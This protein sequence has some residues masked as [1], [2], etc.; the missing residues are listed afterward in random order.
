M[1]CFLLASGLL[2]IRAYWKR[3]L[4]LTTDAIQVEFLFGLRTLRFD[5]ILGR[6]SKATRYG[7]CTVLV[8]KEKYQPKLIVKEGYVVDDSYR[9][10]LASIPDLDIADKEKR[11][12]AGKLHFWES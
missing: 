6:R 5:D 7:S 4:V 12:S 9:S 1:G 2:H 8:P 3:I 11:R 10:W